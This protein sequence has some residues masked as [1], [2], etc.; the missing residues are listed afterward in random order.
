MTK[1]YILAISLFIASQNIFGQT[2]NDAQK[3]GDIADS[4]YQAKSY[5]KATNYYIQVIGIADFNSKK[6]N[7]APKFE[8]FYQARPRVL[9]L[10]LVGIRER[11]RRANGPCGQTEGLIV[12]TSS[13]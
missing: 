4:L 5:A 8:V 12:L 3:L 13:L 10:H 6:V 2:N 1:K 11:R 9:L 7:A